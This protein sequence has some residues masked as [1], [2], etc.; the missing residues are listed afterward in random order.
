MTAVYVLSGWVAASIIAAAFW[1]VLAR[2]SRVEYAAAVLAD[3]VRL[4]EADAGMSPSIHQ[5]PELE[6]EKTYPG[7]PKSIRPPPG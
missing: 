4:L 3:R 2:L 5:A 6:D 1:A 7:R